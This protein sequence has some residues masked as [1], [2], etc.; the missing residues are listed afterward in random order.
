M[1]CYISTTKWVGKKIFSGEYAGGTPS[2]SDS[3]LY[4]KVFF[5]AITKLD[6]KKLQL[7][8]SIFEK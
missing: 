6:E 7:C 4:D 5:V 8:L 2:F 1:C 3:F